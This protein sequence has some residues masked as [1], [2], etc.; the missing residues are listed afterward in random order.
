M[1]SDILRLGYT[2]GDNFKTARVLG[3]VGHVEVYRSGPWAGR[4]VLNIYYPHNRQ[5]ELTGRSAAL[6][7]GIMALSTREG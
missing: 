7:R 4:V 1:L 2:K 6:V 5:I 3:G